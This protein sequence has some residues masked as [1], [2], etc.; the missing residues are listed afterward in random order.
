M[1]IY[2]LTRGLFLSGSSLSHASATQLDNIKQAHTNDVD[3]RLDDTIV[4]I[5]NMVNNNLRN[6]RKDTSHHHPQKVGRRSRRRTLAWDRVNQVSGTSSNDLGHSKVVDS[7]TDNGRGNREVLFGTE[8]EEE[9]SEGDDEEA[10]DPHAERETVLEDD[11]TTVLGF[12][13]HQGKIGELA[14]QDG[15]QDTSTTGA[16]VGQTD[17]VLSQTVAVCE[18]HWR[19]RFD[20]NTGLNRQ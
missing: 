17:L 15:A 5:P 18:Q 1:S 11:F 9:G 2:L 13:A 6:Q 16:E 10:G 14:T 8:T 19:E 20:Y 12:G 7:K 4:A 3:S